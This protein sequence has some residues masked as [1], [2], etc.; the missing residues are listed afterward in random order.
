MTTRSSVITNRF[1]ALI[2]LALLCLFL[3]GCGSRVERGRISGK[4]TFQ[5]QPVSEGL[6]LFSDAS[7]G[8][9][10]MADLKSD[11]AYEITTAEGVGLP[12]GTYRVCVCPPLAVPTTER[13]PA[14]EL[15]VHNNIPKR[16]SHY[17]TSGLTLTVKSGQNLLDI[18]MK[19]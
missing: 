11:G 19:P 14:P 9:H 2:S 8:I 4:V 17:E 3:T 6:V 16:Y 10:M 12:L 7:K 1:S 5:Q 13:G 18:D 15:K